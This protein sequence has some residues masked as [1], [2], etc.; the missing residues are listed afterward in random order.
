MEDDKF[1][2][3]ILFSFLLVLSGQVMMSMCQDNERVCNS[4]STSPVHSDLDDAKE[5]VVNAKT[6]Q[7]LLKK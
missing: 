3:L 5:F 7:L 4:N 2:Y 1:C 6:S